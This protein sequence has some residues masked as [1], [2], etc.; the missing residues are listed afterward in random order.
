MNLDDIVSAAIEGN[1]PWRIKGTIYRIIGKDEN[2]ARR[3]LNKELRA[4]LDGLRYKS[5]F[6]PFEDYNRDANIQVF[7]NNVQ[8][9]KDMYYNVSEFEGI[10]DEKYGGLK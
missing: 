7:K 4:R 9:F 10:I 5:C 2:K 6:K 3:P 8:Y 1:I